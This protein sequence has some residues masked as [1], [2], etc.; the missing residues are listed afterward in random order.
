MTPERWKQI[1]QLYHAALKLEPG[2]Q[3]AF[4]QDACAAD[5][6]LRREVESLLAHEP[7]GESFI[8]ASALEGTAPAMAEKPVQSFVGQQLGSYKIVSLLGVG[9]MGEVYRA[10]DTRLDRTVALKILPAE[11]AADSER[12]RRFTR[13]AKAASALSHPNVAHIYDIGDFEGIHFIAMEYIEGETL[14]KRIHVSQS[15]SPGPS[16]D[17][18]LSPLGKRNQ[19]NIETLPSP[20]GRG[21]RG[22]GQRGQPLE[23]AEILEI[24][25]QVADA[26]DEAHT[27]GITHRDIKPGNI[28]LTPRGQVKV[29]DFGLAKITQPEGEARSSDL[30]TLVKTETGVVMGTV[31]YMSPEQAL[32]KE[33][34][35]RTDIFSLGVVLYEMTTGR[36]PFAGAN[37]SETMDR[38]LH[39]QLEAIARFNYNAP[40]E[41]ERIVRKC[42]EKDRERRYQSA[43]ELLI[44]LKNLKRDSESSAVIAEKVTFQ[45]RSARHRL[46]FSAV[47]LAIVALVAV[48][49][50]LFMMRGKPIDSVAILPRTPA[51]APTPAIKSINPAAYDYY[52]RGKVKV[53]SQNRENNEAAIKLLEQA[54]A[55]DPGFAAAYAELARAYNMKSFNFASDAE[56]KRLNE[57]AEVAIEKALALNPD[58]AEGHFARGLILWTHAKRFPHEQAIQSYK[59]SL[60]LNPNLDEAHHQ[61]ALVYI[62]IGLLD[63]AWEETERALAINPNNTLARF[64]FGVIDLYRGKYEEALAVFK[65]TPPEVYPTIVDRNLATVLFQLGRAGEAAAVVEEY[66][67]TYSQDEGGGVTSVKAMLLA[68]AGKQHEAENAIQRAIEIGKGFGHFHHTAY[69]IAS[70]YA[71]LN[72]PEDAIK[73]LE[74]AAEDGFPCY[75]FFQ[76]DPKLDNLR[77]DARFIG[78]MTKLREQWEQYKATL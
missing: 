44:D 31:Q 60:A 51:P 23:N 17:G 59:R 40:A 69:D 22:E 53:S 63:K 36:L 78:F 72:K 45:V 42:L 20:L 5:E 28:M 54:I 58:L 39:G 74:A 2:Q 30:S 8:E 25:I 52:V 24:S 34:D 56:K 77:Q 47:T 29:L 49:L 15:P 14:A 73:W 16:A 70:A 76:N 43:R 33:M 6:D 57:D 38:I 64:R 18:P 46:A 48:V 62:H 9:G 4:L 19:K 12:M 50:Y 11:V 27:K 55:T 71:L 10:R 32:G 75:P 35:Q 26:L 66:L 41:L 21:A 37:T 7:Q 3:S 68:K 1:E 61:L 65:S 67:K 13:E